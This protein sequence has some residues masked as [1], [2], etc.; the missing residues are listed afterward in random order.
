V[1]DQGLTGEVISGTGDQI[2]SNIEKKNLDDADK[3]P[4]AKGH[5]RYAKH[6]RKQQSEFD[7]NSGQVKAGHDVETAPGEEL[8]T[9]DELL[10]KRN[11][12]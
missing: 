1:N 4:E 10:R 3:V 12:V 5:D 2:N 8:L 11:A 7:E 6:V 9:Q